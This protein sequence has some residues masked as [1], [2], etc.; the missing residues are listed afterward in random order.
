[1]VEYE[2]IKSEEISFGKS[3]FLEVARKKAKTAEGE[4]EFIS[5]A[6]GFVLMN[7]QKRYTQSFTVPNSKEIVDFVVA[8]LKEML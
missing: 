1:M 8:K 6:K 3:S 7:G 5:L 4:T 2:T